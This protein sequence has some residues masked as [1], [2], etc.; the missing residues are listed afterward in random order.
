MRAM[1]ALLLC[2]G[3]VSAALAQFEVTAVERFTSLVI[4]DAAQ[5]AQ[6]QQASAFN[7]ESHE[8]TSI[9]NLSEPAGNIST[10]IG[11]QSFIEPTHITGY[12]GV[13]STWEGADRVFADALSQVR[14]EFSVAAPITVRL[15]GY[16]DQYDVHTLAAVQLTHGVWWDWRV[17]AHDLTT[18]SFNELFTL[19]PGDYELLA[20]AAALSTSG[21]GSSWAGFSFEFAPVPEPMTGVAFLVAVMFCRRRA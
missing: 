5:A 15:M 7:D 2:A 12:T 17:M 19:E 20:V 4:W 21:T 1:I 8:F 16:V 3:G 14:V 13:G 18:V 10:W 6:L 11:H 9:I